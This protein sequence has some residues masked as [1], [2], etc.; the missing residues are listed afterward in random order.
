LLASAFNFSYFVRGIFLRALGGRNKSYE[1]NTQRNEILWNSSGA[2]CPPNHN[3]IG[4][5][6]LSTIFLQT[7]IKGALSN[8]FL[9]IYG[10]VDGEEN[11]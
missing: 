10:V 2:S 1:I 7:V 9:Y 4:N 11:V 5:L 6:S 8:L 3:K